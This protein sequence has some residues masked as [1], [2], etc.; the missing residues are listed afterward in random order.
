MDWGRAV[1]ADPHH[2]KATLKNIFNLT[3]PPASLSCDQ[4]LKSWGTNT[5]QDHHQ[6][7]IHTHLSHVKNVLYSHIRIYAAIYL[8]KYT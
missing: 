1:A 3:G 4:V 6:P 5:E 7:H 8:Q 2:I